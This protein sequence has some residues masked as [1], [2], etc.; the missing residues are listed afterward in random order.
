MR[1][2]IECLSYQ[3]AEGDV[4]NTPLYRALTDA[5]SVVARAINAEGIWGVNSISDIPLTPAAQERRDRWRDARVLDARAARITDAST[6]ITK[7]HGLA[8]VPVV[9][10]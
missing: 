8:S 5:E 10:K 1:G 6:I 3:C 7:G 4:P 9:L 2:S